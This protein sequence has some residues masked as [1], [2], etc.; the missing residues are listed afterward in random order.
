MCKKRIEIDEIESVTDWFR[1]VTMS[2][3]YYYIHTVCPSR[4][5]RYDTKRMK[6]EGFPGYDYFFCYVYCIDS[7]RKR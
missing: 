3:I 6:N 7:I 1:Y 2:I 5:F 4:L